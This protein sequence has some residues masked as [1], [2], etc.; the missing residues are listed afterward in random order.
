MPLLCLHVCN[1]EILPPDLRVCDVI[2]LISSLLGFSAQ[3]EQEISFIHLG[4][5][6][7]K[8]R[9]CD[10]TAEQAAE[11]MSVCLLHAKR[12]FYFVDDITR[13]LPVKNIWELTSLMEKLASKGAAVFFVTSE[14]ILKI[15]KRNNQSHLLSPSKYWVPNIQCA[16]N[17]S[18][19][20]SK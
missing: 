5:E 10:L 14:E 13:E 4:A 3:E 6:D 7:L 11:V 9:I 2:S 18:P 1:A 19:T 17:I 20:D 8:S 16:V 12:D 15:E